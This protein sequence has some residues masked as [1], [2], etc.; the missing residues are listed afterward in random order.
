MLK[1]FSLAFILVVIVL[2]SCS[3]QER[4]KGPSDIIYVIS[5][6]KVKETLGFAIDTT[7]SYGLRTPEFQHYYMTRWFPLSSFKQFIN[8]KN[9]IAI[10]DLKVNDFGLQL[11][12]SVLSGDQFQLAETD[13]IFMFA[14]EDHWVKGQMFVLIAGKDLEKMKKNI[15]QQKAWLY[16]KFDKKFKKEQKKY[17]FSRMEQKRTSRYLWDRYK[18]TMR[19]QHDYRIVHEYPDKKFVWIGRGF[20]NRWVSVSWD[21]GIKTE[22]M[23]PNGLYEKRSEIGELYKGIKTDKRFLGNHF[24]K[25]GNWEALHMSG[26]WYHEKDVKG[27]PFST[28]AF[29]DDKSDRTFVIDAMMFAPGQKVSILFRHVKIMAETFTTSFSEDIFKK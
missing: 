16:T 3:R 21:R 20:P 9:L 26:L 18:W 4:A 23:T 29:Y 5:S 11:S 25:F 2:S 15:L 6:E 28:Y 14:S 17:I 1:K 24:T 8:Y 7:F 19:V 22:W 13:S 12:K 10:S 27:G